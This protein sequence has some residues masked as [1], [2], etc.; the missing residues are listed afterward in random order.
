MQSGLQY[1]WHLKA[2]RV[3]KRGL[4]KLPKQSAHRC[5]LPEKFS[6]LCR[7]NGYYH[8]LKV[9]TAVF[10]LKTIVQFSLLILSVLLMEMICSAP[11]FWDSKTVRTQNH[12]PC[13]IR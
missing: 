1:M 9:Q 7:G 5:I 8:Q 11:V 2:D 13:T 6:K 10:L 12:A 3:K 4:L